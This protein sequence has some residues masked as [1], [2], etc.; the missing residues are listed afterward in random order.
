MS[1]KLMTPG[2]GLRPYLKEESK[3]EESSGAVLPPA[4]LLF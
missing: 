2:T 3:A 4:L 1:T